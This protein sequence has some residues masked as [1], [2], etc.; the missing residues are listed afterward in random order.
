MN[1]QVYNFVKNLNLNGKI[2]DVGSLDVNGSVRNLFSDYT[3]VDMRE[4][5]NVD[6][7]A[8]ANKLPFDDATF[9]NVVCLEMLEHDD[10]FWESIPEM[11]RV[12]KPS[13]M[14]AITARGINFHKHGYPCDYWRFTGDSMRLLLKDLKNIYVNDNTGENGVFACGY[15]Q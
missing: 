7:V 3:G 14:F 6:I 10:R 4:G 15:K 12:L 5:K 9:D 2:L 1:Q 13:G 8:K 11:L